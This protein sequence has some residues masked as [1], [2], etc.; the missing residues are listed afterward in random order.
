MKSRPPRPKQKPKAR[1]KQAPKSI[2]APGEPASEPTGMAFPTPTSPQEFDY[3]TL[4]APPSM[5]PKGSGRPARMHSTKAGKQH[6]SARP[7][8][9]RRGTEA[10]RRGRD[11][12]PAG[13]PR[14][15]RGSKP[16]PPIG[17]PVLTSPRGRPPVL[18]SL[19]VAP[20]DVLAKAVIQVAKVVE[21]A[22]FDEGKR[23]DRAIAFALR[24]RRDL[25]APDHRFI[26]QAIFALFRWH[27]WIKS[28]N[29]LRIEERLLLSWLLDSTIVHP[30][31]R[32]WGQAIGRDASR[33]VPMGDA[34]NWTVRAEAL[35]RWSGGRGVNVDP[36]KLVPGWVREHLP[37]VPAG[38]SP[39]TKYLELLDSLQRRAPLWV[40][41]QGPDEKKTWKELRDAGLKPWLHREIDRAA[42]LEPDVEIYQLPP[43]VRGELEIQDLASQAVAMVCD[44]DPGERWWDT[45]AGAGGKALHLAALMG[46]RGVVVATDASEYR[47]KEAVRRARKSP[48]RNITT[49]TWDGRH[50]A[51]K[52]GSF[53]GV[54]VD[55]PC[56]GIGTWRRNP[57]AR[58]TLQPD[59]IDRLAD[60]QLSLLNAA[61]PG[62]KPGGTLVY[63]VCTITPT[64][65]TGV[66]NEFLQAHPGFKLDPFEHPL[67]K[68]PTNGTLL[69]WPGESDTDA[70]FVARMVKTSS[71]KIARTKETPKEN[72]AITS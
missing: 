56:S 14:S 39:K 40:R 6:E 27:G 52:S 47:L 15:S 60:T 53:D 19:H 43:F 62:V 44:P 63:S 35:K 1:I 72:P 59:A 68:T 5:R 30:V 71:P 31:C 20:L 10:P 28:L 33:L 42:K 48:F 16:T 24:N 32:I 8:T 18:D 57:E 29:V 3:R 51:G 61:A 13:E 64:E 2:K 23:A 54:L 36:W 4:G 37:K 41:A 69:I 38:A 65:T 55:A 34:P 11:A 25:A 21:T 66:V 7:R 70:M 45:C 17:K 12:K 50:V 58:W 26:A 9:E 46:G 49:K 22:V 67:L